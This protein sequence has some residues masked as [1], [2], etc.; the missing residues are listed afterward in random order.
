M[1]NVAIMKNTIIIVLLVVLLGVGFYLFTDRSTN[2]SYNTDMTENTETQTQEEESMEETEIEKQTET[3]I[4]SSVNGNDIIAYHFGKGETNLLFVSGIHGDY[5]ANTISLAN[6]VIDYLEENPEIIPENV[7]VSIIPVLNVDGT[8]GDDSTT[9]VSE[10]RFNAN[11]VDLNRNF[12]CNWQEE[13][14]WQSKKVSGGDAPFSEPESKAL[15]SFVEDINPEA[16][17]VWYSAAGGVYASNCNEGVLSETSELTRLF[18]RESG[19]PAYEDFDF[20]KIT[21]D[22][23]NWLAKEGIPAISILLTNHQDTEFNKNLEGIKAIFDYY[24]E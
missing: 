12:D 22:A 4:G 7:R 5:E 17:V 11:G 24:A 10:G 2:D 18:A 20:Y 14:V 15:K 23:T 9:E 1:Y 16:V 19:Y 13:G 3:V 21:G 8:N 6:Q